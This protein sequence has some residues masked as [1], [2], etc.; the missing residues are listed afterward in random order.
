MP[1]KHETSTVSVVIDLEWDNYYLSYGAQ[2]VE[3]RLRSDGNEIVRLIKTHVIPH[4][5]PF[6]TVVRV[7]REY[8]C[9]GCG[10]AWTEKSPDY[11][12]GCCERDEARNP[13]VLEAS[14]SSPNHTK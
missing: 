8:V 11:N 5:G 7:E 3:D 1:R 4:A 10:H 9:D 12:G 6:S 2:Q 13:E 14:L